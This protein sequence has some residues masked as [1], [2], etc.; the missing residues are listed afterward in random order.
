[1]DYSREARIRFRE[2]QQMAWWVRLA[3]WAGIVATA[4]GLY[5]VVFIPGAPP[6]V[7][8]T[9]LAVLV[10]LVILWLVF[11]R[12]EIVL[13]DQNLSFG[14]WLFR[15]VVPLKSIVSCEPQKITLWKYGGIGIRV[16]ARAVC[17]NTC[18]GDGVRIRVEGRRKDWVFSCDDAPRLIA[19]LNEE[20]AKRGGHE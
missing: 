2:V 17:Y 14:F 12:L 16:A 19:L 13:D 6:D 11:R 4:V 10:I 5:A 20:I 3:F 9:V 15:P 7:K 1:M 8:W 18:F